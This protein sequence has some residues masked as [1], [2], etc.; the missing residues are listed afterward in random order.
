M[1][2]QSITLCPLVKEN[3]LACAQLVLPPEQ[4][5]LLAPNIYSI[6]ESKFEPHYQPRVI[7]L[8]GKEIGFL[9]YCPDVDLPDPKLFW[10]F[11][12]MLGAEYQGKGYGALAIHLALAE[13]KLA[14]A[15]RVR[16]MHKPSNKIASRLYQRS[17]FCEV[18]YAEDGDVELELELELII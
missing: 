3:W 14:G 8:D 6:A 5:T 17:G 11:R 7:C 4:A 18:G 2:T 9:M 10:L 12:F 1:L 16:T 13:M 15:S